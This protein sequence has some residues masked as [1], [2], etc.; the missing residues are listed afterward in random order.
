[1]K[2][3]IMCAM[4]ALFS[5]TTMAGTL[6]LTD[7]EHYGLTNPELEMV[8]DVSTVTSSVQEELSVEELLD[9]L[10]GYGLVFVDLDEPVIAPLVLT[11]D[12]ALSPDEMGLENY[13][14]VHP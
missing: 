14:L 6:D 5:S 1:M 4:A 10:P 12:V 13:G 9:T 7:L 8:L 3:F 2:Y 11:E